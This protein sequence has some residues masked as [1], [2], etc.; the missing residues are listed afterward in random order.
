MDIVQLVWQSLFSDN[1]LA[2]ETIDT[3][4]QFR[5]YLTGI[6]RNKVREEYRRGTRTRKYD[7]AREEPLDLRRGPGAEC[8]VAAT[9]PSPSARVVADECWESILYGGSER[10]IQ[11]VEM[12]R[13]GLTFEQIAVELGISDRTIRRQLDAVRERLDQRP[14]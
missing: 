4:G 1:D 5:G 13:K 14:M 6:A 9:D 10:Q 7:L 12:R 3:P 11:I 2:A 8:G